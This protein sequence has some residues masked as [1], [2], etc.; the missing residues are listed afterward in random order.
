MSQMQIDHR[1]LNLLVSEELLDGVEM[2]A[3][4]QEMGCKAVAQSM[5][6]GGR[7]IE[8]FANHEDQAL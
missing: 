5:D 3:G 4:F 8:F 7:E 1:A 2:S 6:R